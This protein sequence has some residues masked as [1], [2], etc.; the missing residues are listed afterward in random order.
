MCYADEQAAAEL[1]L[2]PPFA[3]NLVLQRGIDLPVWGTAPSGATVTVIFEEQFK[4]TK[5]DRDGAWR[6]E[7]EPLK[8][9][10]LAKPQSVPEGKVM[11]VTAEHQGKESLIKLENLVVGDVWLCAG[12]SN[13]AGRLKGN[14]TYQGEVANYPGFRHW[15]PGS[16]TGWL[17]CS[18]E[19]AGQFKKT[20]FYFGRDVYRESR[21]PIGLVVSAVGG[22]KI[23]SWLN[24]KPY[25]KGNNY[26]KLIEPIVGMGIRGVVWYQGESNANK[27]EPY[28]PLLTSLIEGWRKAWGQGDFPVYF[29]QLPGIGEAKN[30]IDESKFG[31]QGWPA[32]RQDQLE[33]L[34][35]KNTGMAV[36]ID[37]GA[38]SVHPPNKLDTGKRLARL[39]LHHDYGMEDLVPTGPLYKSHQIQG[40]T[41]R[42]QFEYADSGLMLARKQGTE[43]PVATPNESL[44]CLAIRGEDGVWHLAEGE[45][46]GTELLVSSEKVS[47]PVAV[48]YAYTPHPSGSLLYNEAGLPASPFET[49]ELK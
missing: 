4:T 3:D 27:R 23:E 16:D 13:M 43:P 32:L 11:T 21:V 2:A 26:T 39:A 24:Q 9:V 8:A 31:R 30:E 49:K 48:R 12:Q 10:Q 40:N 37:I 1:S 35:V 22:S 5:A 25:A 42:V 14:G 20:A 6:I 41:I 47:D 7:L 19:S 46:D 15:N 28:R 44:Q 45:I 34:S 38:R 17:V 33:T 29:V 36:T 18:P